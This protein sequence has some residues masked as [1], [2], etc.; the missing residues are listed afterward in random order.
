MCCPTCGHTLTRLET[1]PSS[2]TWLCARC[3]T[4]VRQYS[5]GSPDDVYVPKL[6]ERCRAYEGGLQRSPRDV[7]SVAEIFGGLQM[8]WHALGI[9]ESIRKPEG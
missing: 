1:Q 4:V 2:A 5:S 7:H 9:A 3:G 6:V 8:N